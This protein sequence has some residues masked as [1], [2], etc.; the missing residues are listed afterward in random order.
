MLNFNRMMLVLVL[1][2]EIQCL[3]IGVVFP[4]FVEKLHQSNLE[5]ESIVFVFVFLK[6]T[7]I[8]EQVGLTRNVFLDER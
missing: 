6:E 2:F 3:N 8:K 7:L 5:S 4:S 1:V